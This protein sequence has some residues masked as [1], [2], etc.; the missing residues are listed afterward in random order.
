[1]EFV[2]LSMSLGGLGLLLLGMHMMTEGLKSAAGHQ[3][4]DFL[5]RST[6]TRL[7]AALT[8]FGLTAVV[9]S[10]SAVIVTTLGFTNAGM[11]RLRQAAWVVFGSNLGTTMTAWIVAIIGL[12]LN[13]SAFAMPLIGIGMLLKLLFSKGR[14]QHIGLAI[15]GFGVL[16]FGLGL[17]KD[18]F[19]GVAEWIPMEQL[20]TAGGLG[21][22]IGVLVGAILTALIQSSSASIAI[23][24]TASV[25]GVLTPLLGAALIIGANIGT[26]ATSLLT[27][28]GA[29]ANARRLALIHVI[30][31]AT[32]AV[33]ALILL[34]PLWFVAEAL[35]DG[36]TGRTNISAGLALFHTLFNVLGLFL[37]WLWSNKLIRFVERLIKQPERNSEKPR[38]LD[39]TVLQIPAM[40]IGAMHSELKRV[41]KQLLARGRKI[42]N[43]QVPMGEDAEYVNTSVLL[44]TIEEYGIKVAQHGLSGVSE[45]FINLNWAIQECNELR[46]SLHDLEA[47]GEA[48]INASVPDSIRTILLEVFASGQLK[49]K[50]TDQRHALLDTLKQ[51]RKQERARL[52]SAVQSN[53]I[54]APTATKHLQIIALFEESARRVIRIADVVY[55][56][57]FDI[58]TPEND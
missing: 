45:T 18:A 10:S 11:L 30:E 22:V 3:L 14:T 58:E 40:G 7:R 54:T 52:L 8:G 38:Y 37:M 13:V 44:R 5:E 42:S 43:P 20:G 39:N 15:A 51:A 34:V 47:F 55:P 35:T 33:V 4:N 49:A 6:Q 28:I 32:T 19:D 53:E 25:T 31:K 57:E 56:A 27:T 9:Q 46:T 12:Q 21:I 48:T 41:F 26:T 24:L 17:L 29:T 50:S 36:E 1:M 2:T 16:F 23:I